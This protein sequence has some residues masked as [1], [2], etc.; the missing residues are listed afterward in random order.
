MITLAVVLTFESLTTASLADK[1][2]RKALLGAA[3][4]LFTVDGH[5]YAVLSDYDLSSYAW[6]PMVALLT[7]IVLASA[8]IIPLETI[9][10]EV[11]VGIS[12]LCISQW[13]HLLCKRI[14]NYN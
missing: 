14:I 10:G 3:L 5:H 6:V 8:G 4:G 2:S 11:R 7:T 1:F 12:S 9:P 13:T